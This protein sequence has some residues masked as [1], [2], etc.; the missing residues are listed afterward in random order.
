[1]KKDELTREELE[2]LTRLLD[3]WFRELLLN[4]DLPISDDELDTKVQLLQSIGLV[5]QTVKA[6]LK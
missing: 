4:T 6:D 3:G 5:S 2:Q 1:M